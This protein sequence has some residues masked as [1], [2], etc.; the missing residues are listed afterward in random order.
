MNITNLQ[1]K[2]EFIQW[3]LDTCLL[4]EERTRNILK[5]IANNNY[6]LHRVRIVENI[7]FMP[8][9]LLVSAKGARTVSYLYRLNNEHYEDSELVI[10][11]LLSNP[12]Q[13]LH[14]WL[15]FDRERMN[16]LADK[17]L[18]GKSEKALE[19]DFI[20]Q[21][22]VFEKAAAEERNN[23]DSQKELL[24]KRID[25]ALIRGDREGFQKLSDR[26]KRISNG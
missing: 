7:R 16:T 17:I 1:Q 26:Y 2:K 6:L 4:K 9:A 20:K 8:N 3:F 10:N 24:L 18:E 13:E 22:E 14:L 5:L 19:E 15:S 21:L 11:K 12:P 23:Q 25:E